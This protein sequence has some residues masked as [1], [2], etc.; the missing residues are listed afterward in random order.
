MPVG[1][2]ITRGSYL[3]VYTNGPYAGQGIGLPDPAGGGWRK[4]LQDK[5]RAAGNTFDFVGE[6][7]YMAYGSNGVVD[8]SF[9]PRHHGLAGFSNQGIMTG[10]VVPTPKDVLDA[11][12]VTEIRVPGI[13]TALANSKPN[14]VL[15]IS[16]AN[17]F[18]ATARDKLIRT[19]MSNTTAHVFVA[20]IPP[21]C[22]PRSGYQNVEPYNQSLPQIVT[23]LKGKGFP[24][25]FVDMYSALS[26]ADLL[27]DGVHPNAG[28]M[29]KMAEVW[30][31][32]LAAAGLTQGGAKTGTLTRSAPN[33]TSIATHFGAESVTI[34]ETSI[35][36]HSGAESVTIPET[37]IA[38][39]PGAVSVTIPGADLSRGALVMTFDDTYA[40]QWLAAA[41][42]FT[43][44]AARVTFFVTG[45][46][47]LSPAQIENL[48]QLRKQGHAIACHGLRHMKAVDYVTAHGAEAYLQ[49][50]IDPANAALAK[51]GFTPTA[52][53]YPS[54]QRNAD[55]DAVLL[56]RFRHLRGGGI[57]AVPGQ[58]L[59]DVDSVFVPAANV[60]K[61]GCLIGAGIDYLDTGG[62]TRPLQQVL[63]ALDRA[64]ARGEV[65]VLYAHNIS[66]T[67]PGHHIKPEVLAKVLAHARTIGLP[68][69]TYDD[70][71]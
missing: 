24:I 26:T 29:A 62:K 42:I 54:S 70:L 23:E 33:A 67:G 9:A 20:T 34:P 19:V 41:P 64:R 6:L 1:D 44:Y 43:Q 8:A 3:A 68:A 16:G 18:D 69:V 37:S 47:K 28:G 12:G 5:L 25:H 22:P 2:S 51:L 71:P 4:P 66:A 56:K 30:F 58:E 27:P 11:K 38:T 17:G 14:V 10:G 39:H 55:T 7:D 59:K 61:T 40:A 63:D 50:E 60:A 35:A 36:T 21:E 45:P 46:D 57:A 31:Q 48:L 52:F 13:V 15:L 49:K 32:A 65:L 53:A